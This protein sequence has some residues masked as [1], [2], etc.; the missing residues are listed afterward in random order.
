MIAWKWSS[1]KDWKGDSDSIWGSEGSYLKYWLHDNRDTSLMT[2]RWVCYHCFGTTG[3]KETKQAWL[4]SAG[5]FHHRFLSNILGGW[6]AV[7]CGE[8]NTHTS[9]EKKKQK[10]RVNIIRIF[11]C[12]HVPKNILFS[13]AGGQMICLRCTHCIIMLQFFSVV[14]WIALSHSWGISVCVCSVSSLGHTSALSLNLTLTLCAPPSRGNTMEAH[15]SRHGSVFKMETICVLYR[16]GQCSS[17]SLTRQAAVL[18]ESD[19]LIVCACASQKALACWWFKNDQVERAHYSALFQFYVRELHINSVCVDVCLLTLLRRM[20][21]RMKTVS[22]C[23]CLLCLPR[24]QPLFS[25]RKPISHLPMTEVHHQGFFSLLYSQSFYPPFHSHEA[26]PQLNARIIPHLCQLPVVP[27]IGPATPWRTLHNDDSTVCKKW[28]QSIIWSS[29]QKRKRTQL[30]LSASMA[31]TYL[32]K[33][34]HCG[35]NLLVIL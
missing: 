4:V 30:N 23:C 10:P 28:L 5:P 8:Q 20:T 7:V 34:P 9:G 3:K 1:Q 12:F 33:A 16:P 15:C 35:E 18:S 11:K 19:D 29:I 14:G 6:V 22:V 17:V 25:G 31:Q 13:G 32:H 27:T 2:N 21:A 26:A 24:T